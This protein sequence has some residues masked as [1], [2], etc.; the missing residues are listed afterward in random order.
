[1][2]TPPDAPDF[3]LSQDRIRAA[4]WA[5]WPWPQPNANAILHGDYWPGNVLWHD[6]QLISV[7]DWE[8]AAFG[9]PLAD[10]ANSR[11]EVLWAFGEAAMQL[12]TAT[13]CAA[14]PQLDL[15]ALPYWDLVAALR[16]CNKIGDWGLAP[17]TE[18]IVR[19]SHRVFVD[20]ALGI[21]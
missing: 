16:P 20:T 8:D 11:L 1:L 21:R 6:G 4:L 14:N 12:F 15:A 7:I 17:A 19:Q 13:Y 3:S 18:R 9:D 10:L 2:H 5:P